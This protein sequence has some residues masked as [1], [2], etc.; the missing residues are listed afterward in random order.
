[1]QCWYL[2][3]EAADNRMVGQAGAYSAGKRRRLLF[4][5]MSA[6]PRA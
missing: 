2:E 4:M 3:W 1:V 5:I 6:K